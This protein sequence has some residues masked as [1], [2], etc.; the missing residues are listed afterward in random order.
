MLSFTRVKIKKGGRVK[1]AVTPSSLEKRGGY[2]GE[3]KNVIKHVS[4]GLSGFLFKTMRLFL[5]Q[6]G[7]GQTHGFLNN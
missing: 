5:V 4:K 7:L 6:V 1:S 2:F 3:N